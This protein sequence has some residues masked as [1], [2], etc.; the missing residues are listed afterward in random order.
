MAEYTR[1]DIKTLAPEIAP[2][3]REHWSER[4][5]HAPKYAL[6][7]NL[8]AYCDAEERETLGLY[9]ARK[10]NKLVGYVIVFIVARPHANGEI[11]A[12]IDA[13]FVLPEHRQQGTATGLLKFAEQD[14]KARGANTMSVGANDP[15][16]IRW[17]RMTGCYNYSETLLEKEL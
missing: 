17:L 2:L 5:A 6:A 16:I 3:L 14:L 11:V 4:H 1:T 13:L 10:S 12:V 9:V 15:R 7:P 8:D